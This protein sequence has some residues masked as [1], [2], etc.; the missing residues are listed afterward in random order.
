MEF[1]HQTYEPGDTVAA[2]ATA[3][4]E[5]GV[6][7]VRI[8]GN[9]AFAVAEKIFTGPVKSYKSHTAHYGSIHDAGAHVDDVLLLPMRGP[10]SFTGEDTVEIFCHGGSLIT[11]RVLEVVLKHGA[12]HASP[13][14]FSFKA[15]MN[16]KVDLAEAEAIQELI[17]AKNERA[18]SAAGNQLQ[19]RLS[20]K[21]VHFEK[22]LTQVA[23]ILEAWVDFPDEGLEFAPIEEVIADLEKTAHSIKTLLD[24][25]HD[26]KIIHEGVSL[27][28]VGSPN[29]GKSSLLNALLGKNRAIV[30]ATAGTTRDVLEDHMRLGGLNIK[31]IDTAGIRETVESIE[32]EG[33]RR[34]HNA[35]DEADVILLVLD[36]TL[37]ESAI[38]QELLVKLNGR[39][40]I[41][42]WNK[43]DLKDPPKG[44]FS[45]FAHIS[46]ETGNGLDSL[47]EL[48][49]KVVFENGAPSKEEVILT[50]E[51]HKEALG[52][53]HESLLK[54]IQGLR[55]GVSPEFLAFDMRD[56]LSNLG[57]IIG[58]NV[59]ED[60]LSSIFSTFCIGK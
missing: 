25:Y 37:G 45:Y 60:V 15:F 23:A 58:I 14:E 34:T 20:E 18:L 16:G 4:G 59:T 2:I 57:K 29:A 30:S 27:C 49:E 50:S 11:K 33:I 31:L 36:S 55:S 22:E 38:D 41:A 28:L 9:R 51:R 24:T 8:S 48:I 46:A 7:M 53:A 21:I 26:G 17:M 39:K 12:R 54:V 19:G 3:P 47:R 35:I 43:I 56:S 32:Q 44:D 1:I 5:G 42:V 10:R 6:A 52:A 13:G 40:M